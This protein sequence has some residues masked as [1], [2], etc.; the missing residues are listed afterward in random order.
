[1]FR[2]IINEK[3][4]AVFEKRKVIAQ[5]KILKE[6]KMHIELE[7]FNFIESIHLK[8]IVI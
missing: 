8:E 7:K 2:D 1:M 4:K 6:K 5:K 3:V